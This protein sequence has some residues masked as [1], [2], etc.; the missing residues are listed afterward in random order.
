MSTVYVQVLGRFEH[1]SLVDPLKIVCVLCIIF[2]G[3]LYHYFEFSKIVHLFLFDFILAP[4]L[5]V[6]GIQE[7]N[8]PIKVSNFGRNKSSRFLTKNVSHSVI[9]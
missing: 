1:I 3:F 2:S 7:S 4:L 5:S 8:F 6:V 9:S